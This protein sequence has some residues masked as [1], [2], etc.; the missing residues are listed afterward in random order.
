[1]KEYLRF[2]GRSLRIGIAGDWRYH[3][4]MT[5]LAAV[6][7]AGLNAYAKQLVHGLATTGMTDQ[8]SWGLYIA[9]F[10]FAE[11]IATALAI[12]VIVAYVY[13]RHELQDLVI[14]AEILAVAALLV[15]LA[16]VVVDLGRP[17][18]FLH[19]LQES[20][21]PNS[22]LAWDV[23]V[24][25]GFLLLNLHLCG[26]PIYCAYRRRRP[27]RWFYV[28]FFFVVI[29]WAVSTQTVSAFLFVGLGSRP[30][31]NTAILAPRFLAAAFAGGP[32]VLI[33][34]LWVLDRFAGHRVPRPAFATLR[35]IVA[36]AAIVH[37]FLLACEVFVAF[38][39]G[40]AHG[41]STRYLY[42]GLHGHDA[43]VPWIRTAIVLSGLG[44]LGLLLPL[45]QR[46]LGRN[47]ACLLLVAGLWIEKGMGF[48]VPA[49]VPSPLGEIVEYTPTVNEI[50]VCLGI[51]AAGAL[52]YS[53]FVRVTIPVLSGR[54]TFDRP[55]DPN[56][57][58]ALPAPAGSSGA[59]R[60][61]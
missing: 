14:F 8:V 31:W 61:G 50:V 55:Y 58:S 25:N 12:V 26:Y 20:N 49:F 5:L 13:R 59:S 17:D 45:A 27:S 39:T 47:L 56:R 52:V 2:L 43:L 38:Y 23:I 40:S 53:I 7:L 32:A 6:A 28:P 42:L 16:F 30:F 24:L 10:V 3:L 21:F 18:R 44:L 1:M 19:L 15:C 4:W 46:P 9:N 36:V 60:E 54:L 57:P 41:S 11:G 29:V 34:I 35:G 37:L 33:P 22:L 51:W 48:V